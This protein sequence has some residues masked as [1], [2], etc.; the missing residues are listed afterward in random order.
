MFKGKGIM[1]RYFS[2]ISF[3]I[4]G[5][6]P[7]GLYTAKHLTKRIADY[8]IDFYEK[9][10]HPF[11]LVRT[12]VAPD[13]Q[14]VKNVMNDFSQ[15]LDDQKVR[16]IGNIE[17][18]KDLSIEDLLENYSAV[19]LAYG[20]DS[21]NSLNLPNENTFGCFSARNFVNWYNGHVKYS[22]SSPFNLI[23]FSAIKDVVIIGNGNVAIDIARFLSEDAN[24]LAKYDVPD[25]ILDKIRNSSV[26]N[27]SIVG[28]RG[29]IQSAFTVKELRELSKL[30][31]VKM[32]L[33]KEEFESS[34]NE[35]SKKEMDALNP[36]ERRHYTRKVELL[37]TF[38]FVNSE[39]EITSSNKEG[40]KNIVL[41]FL[42][43]P[44]EIL[45][46]QE[47][48]TQIQFTKTK[49]SG[50]A[51]SQTAERTDNTLSL[52]ADL[53][54]KSIGY[55][56]VQLFDKF[57]FDNSK[58]VVANLD[59]VVY[60]KDG[61]LLPNVF[62]VG[63]A[64]RGA[65]GIIDSTLRDSYNTASSI[66]ANVEN[67]VLVHK[68]PDYEK[69]MKKVTD[70]GVVPINYDQWKL[71]NKFELMQGTQKGKIRDKLIDLGSMFD[72]IKKI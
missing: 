16:F 72:V 63:W 30:E 43:A 45:V 42:L 12:G 53:I 64:K 38:N 36:A 49:L 29:I 25:N 57:S 65:K 8:Q 68:I 58:N 62:T 41:R 4:I 18:G 10:P 40:E 22:K 37:K 23:D 70:N 32:F 39:N 9:L 51:H 55:K 6:G 20:A 48:V 44:K 11:G 2:T 5:S 71:I 56:T 14:D 50:N 34:L 21:E 26:K 47:K 15:I 19:I 54:L 33:Y 60:D 27:I 24:N 17:V 1:K 31:N 66:I 13:H 52:R 61:K 59:G 67:K 7:G 35:I 46:E 28:R 69:L 3:A